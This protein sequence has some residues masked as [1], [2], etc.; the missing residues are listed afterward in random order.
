MDWRLVPSRKAGEEG[1]EP[2]S[3][4]QIRF[5]LGVENERA[6]GGRDGRTRLV[7]PS[8]QGANGD[9]EIFILPGERTTSRITG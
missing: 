6:D 4:H 5:T 2:V 1:E 8:S 9:S 3:K 7:R